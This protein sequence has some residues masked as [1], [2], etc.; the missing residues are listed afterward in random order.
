MNIRNGLELITPET[1]G[2]IYMTHNMV[3]GKK[4]IGQKRINATGT[5]WEDYLGSGKLLLRAVE[6]YGKENFYKDIL[7]VAYDEGELNKKEIDWIQKYDA[8][9]DE[10]FYNLDGG[11][12]LEGSASSNYENETKEA[13]FMRRSLAT[14]KYQKSKQGHWDAAKLTEEEVKD[15]VARFLNSETIYDV[16]KVYP[17]VSMTTLNDIRAHKRW[18]YLTEGIEFPDIKIKTR[19]QHSIPIMQ[20]D[21]YGGYVNSYPNVAAICEELGLTSNTAIQFAARNKYR[22]SCGYIWVKKDKDWVQDLKDNTDFLSSGLP[23]IQYVEKIG[24]KPPANPT[25]SVLQYDKQHNF[26]KR[27]RSIKEAAEATN[28]YHSCISHVCSGRLH[29]TGGFIWKYEDE[30]GD[31]VSGSTE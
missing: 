10:N 23:V 30:G 4:Y 2:F 17:H 13:A 6:K 8:V 25:R 21:L 1:Y 19:R 7:D 16:S 18:K 26:I 5:Y 15:I 29:S 27:Y 20:Y 9:R 24:L 14:S 3:N 22:T 12:Y 11:G 31:E 28:T